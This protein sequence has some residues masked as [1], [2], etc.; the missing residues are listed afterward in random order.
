VGSLRPSNIIDERPAE[1]TVEDATVPSV[2]L[3]TLKATGPRTAAGKERSKHNAL[4]HGI[5]A[6]LVLVDGEQRSALVALLTGIRN[7][8]RP[9]GTLEEV[10]VEKLASLLWRYRRLLIAEG[11]EIR[12]GTQFH[13]SDKFAREGREAA[14]FL[15]S[16]LEVRAGLLAGAENSCIRELCLEALQSL[17]ESIATMGFRVRL[18]SRILVQVYGGDELRSVNHPLFLAYATYYRP[19]VSPG[20]NQE[21][22]DP[23]DAEKRKAKFLKILQLQIDRLQGYSDF[24]GERI[25]RKDKLEALR[26]NVPSASESDR[27]LRYE[28][29][30]ERSIDRTL[31]QL[32]RLQQMR[33]GQ[34]VPPKLEVQLS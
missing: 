12:R 17:K 29:S 4:K 34:P 21:R 18:D 19:V 1:G 30:L 3:T 7:D 23:A 31:S 22:E 13:R 8:L 15:R 24:D 14:A 11:A 2:S 5:F 9:E 16:E 32:E 10:L 33:L 27:F 6:K 20:V 25:A 26:C 28:A